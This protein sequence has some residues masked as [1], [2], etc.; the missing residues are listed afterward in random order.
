MRGQGFQ[1]KGSLPANSRP[2]SSGSAVQ[3]P[4][5]DIEI[6]LSQCETRLA[7]IEAMMALTQPEGE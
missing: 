7:Q 6:R 1:P 5:K 3:E 2:P 4:R